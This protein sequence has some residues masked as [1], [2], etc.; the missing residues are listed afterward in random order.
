VQIYIYTNIH[1]QIYKC[2]TGFNY[3]RHQNEKKKDDIKILK[4]SLLPDNTLQIFLNPTLFLN[5]VLL[6]S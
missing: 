6:K 2:D 1:V 5:V 3:V 4:K